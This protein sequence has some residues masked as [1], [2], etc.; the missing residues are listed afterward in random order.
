MPIPDINSSL[1]LNLLENSPSFI[2]IVDEQKRIFWLNQAFCDFIGLERESLIGLSE[3]DIKEPC[4]AQVLNATV[5]VEIFAGILDKWIEL[6]DVMNFNGEQFG[7]ENQNLTV[8][9]YA[10]A[11]KKVQSEKQL[12]Q[13]ESTLT[14]KMSHDSVTGMLNHHSMF[15]TLSSEVSRSRRYNN[16]LSLVLMNV[17]YQLGDTVDQK[18]PSS[19]KIEQMRL[20]ISQLLKDQMR[21]A[22][23]VGHL[24][25]YDFVLLLP[26][27]A[28]QSAEVLIKK[29]NESMH[30]VA[31]DAKHIKY[32]ISQWK[33]GDDIQMFMERAAV[34]L[35]SEVA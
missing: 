16:P 33:K 23:I 10:D 13:L 7:Q 1:C 17:N 20:M 18:T 14:H 34:E 19:E 35:N 21:W 29:L 28:Y 22:D 3:N 6:Q 4:L 12:M 27:T 32:G 9:Y 15:Q 31:L 30:N 24:E 2:I 25:D 8:C 5:R 26:E 11:S